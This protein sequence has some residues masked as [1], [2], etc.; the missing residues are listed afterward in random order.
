M[1]RDNWIVGEYSIRPAGDPDKCFYCGVHKGGTHKPECVI[2]N[3]TV[4]L[5]MTIDLVVE[6]PEDW[7]KQ[8][9]EFNKNQGTWC[10]SNI[11]S[12]LERLDG[13]AGCLC[14]F[15]EFEY[16]REATQDDEEL[17]GVYVNKIE[18]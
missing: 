16:I 10:A 3:R 4:V 9:I 2:R 12:E 8:T 6:V 18:S 5:K 11:L 14:P 1:K 13:H 15:M 17:Y 7:D